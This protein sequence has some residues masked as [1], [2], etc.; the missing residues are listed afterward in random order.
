[1]DWVIFVFGSCFMLFFLV[2]FFFFFFFKIKMENGP[3]LTYE[4]Q[5][6]ETV[7]LFGLFGE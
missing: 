3:S 2:P 4:K 1:M 6:S 5:G 7:T